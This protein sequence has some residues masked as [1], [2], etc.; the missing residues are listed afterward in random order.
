MSTLINWYAVFPL[1]DQLAI[2]RVYLTIV[3]S[4]DDDYVWY[5]NKESRAK[6][7]WRWQMAASTVKY[8]IT[9]LKKKGFLVIKS[10]G[11]YEISKK[12]LMHKDD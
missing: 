2:I 11:V 6:I 10:R 8:S 3:S 9:Q 7:E 1:I 12:Y 5:S 4:M